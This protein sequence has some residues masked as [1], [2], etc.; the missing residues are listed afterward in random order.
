MD[1]RGTKRLS[2]TGR[3]HAHML[4][5]VL[6]QRLNTKYVHYN[7]HILHTVWMLNMY[8]IIVIFSTLPPPCTLFMIGLHLHRVNINGKCSGQKQWHENNGIRNAT[9]QEHTNYRVKQQVCWA[10]LIIRNR[11]VYR[12]Y[13]HRHSSISSCLTTL[14]SQFTGPWPWRCREMKIITELINWQTNGQMA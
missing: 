4:R 1:N 11:N 13:I 12:R 8:I 7:S 2:I 14:A 6:C 5:D 9:L 10:C 3:Q